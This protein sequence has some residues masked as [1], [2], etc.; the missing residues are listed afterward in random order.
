M[1]SLKKSPTFFQGN[2]KSAFCR[3]ENY[4]YKICFGEKYNL[5]VS[6]HKHLFDKLFSLYLR[7]EHAQIFM[8]LYF[9][10]SVFPNLALSPCLP[11]LS[12]P[13]QQSFLVNTSPFPGL[14]RQL[15]LHYIWRQTSG[16]QSVM[17]PADRPRLTWTIQTLDTQ[18]PAWQSWESRTFAIAPALS[19]SLHPSL[20]S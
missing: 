1:L 9:S 19:T 3:N 20:F 18:L 5:S 7:Y 12:G 13:P 11:K 8:F 14:S 4:S 15:G 2:E 10:K 16:L 6:I 17:L